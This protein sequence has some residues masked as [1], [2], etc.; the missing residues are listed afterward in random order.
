MLGY[1][2]P[3]LF[4][5]QCH[6][7]EVSAGRYVYPIFK[8]GSSSLRADARQLDYSELHN[9]RTVEVFLRE[10]FERYVSG[11]QTYLKHLG[12]DYDRAT[13]LAMIHQFLFLNRHFA[14]QFHWLMNLARYTDAQMTF[15]PMSELSTVT[16]YTF[17][18]IARDETL[19]EYFKDNQ[20]LQYYL[21][22]DKILYE[23][24][25]GQTVSFKRIIQHIKERHY[26]LY[27][28]V[29]NRSLELCNVLD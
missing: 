29:I 20:K 27:R 3:I 4:P 22:L 28:E 19:V 5:D 14:L 26:Y 9:I 10:P 12:P 21:T 13:V 18:V 2:D 15:S 11:V 6:V 24:F 23:E 16:K 8:N 17:N 1:L 7:Y 25:I